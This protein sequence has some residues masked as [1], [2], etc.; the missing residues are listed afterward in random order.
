[1]KRFETSKLLD[2]YAKA[3][4]YDEI[5]REGWRQEARLFSFEKGEFL[6]RRDQDFDYMYLLVKGKVKVFTS[7]DN[8]KVY[9]INVESAPNSYGDLE[10]FK[11]ETYS[12][13]AQAVTDL[14]VIGVVRKYV[15]KTCYD[16]PPFLRFI[17]DSLGRRLNNITHISSQNLCQPLKVKLAGY[18]VLHM[19]DSSRFKLFT[20]M[21]DVADHLGATYRHISR[22][23]KELEEDGLILKDGKWIEILD[24]PAMKDLAGDMYRF[25]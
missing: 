4:H 10:L 11:K 14:I 15:E 22:T 25:D 6:C 19:E 23:F 21:T 3:Y 17:A 5:F 8:G 9:L 2:K 7:Q 18:L 1:M 12:A 13:N 20:S 24:E 16:Y